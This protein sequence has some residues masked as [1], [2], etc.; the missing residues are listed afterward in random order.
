MNRRQINHL[1]NIQEQIDFLEK[2]LERIDMAIDEKESIYFTYQKPLVLYSG[3]NE[4]FNKRLKTHK[5]KIDRAYYNYL[6]QV[7]R[8]LYNQFIFLKLEL[9]KS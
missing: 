5:N 9:N 4:A 8:T 1:Q 3:D 7:R 6:S 2:E